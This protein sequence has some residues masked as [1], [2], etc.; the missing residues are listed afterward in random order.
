MAVRILF[1]KSLAAEWTQVNPIL[2]DGEPGVE[3]DTLRMKFGDGATA[4]VD[5]PYTSPGADGPQGEKGDFSYASDLIGTSITELTIEDDVHNLTATTGKNWAPGMWMTLAYTTDPTNYMVGLCISY[6]QFSGALQVYVNGAIYGTD[7]GPHS[8]W[9]LSYAASAG[10]SVIHANSHIPGQADELPMASAS[11][12]GF[13]DPTKFSLLEQI[14]ISG[15]FI[16]DTQPIDMPAGSVWFNTSDVVTSPPSVTAIYPQ[17]ELVDI[18]FSIDV[19]LTDAYDM[20]LVYLVVTATTNSG[21][22]PLSAI[23]TRGSGNHQFVDITACA[24]AGSAIITITAVN[25]LGLSTDVA[26]PVYIVTEAYTITASAG[27]HGTIVPSG[28]ILVPS[29]GTKLFTTTANTGYALQKFTVDSVDYTGSNSYS[30]DMEGTDHTIVATFVLGY[31]ITASITAAGGGTLAPNG[32]VTV[33][34][35]DDL[36]LNFAGSTGYEPYQYFIDNDGVPHDASSGT[37]TFNNVA[38]NHNFSVSF[39]AADFT[40]TWTSLT[41]GLIEGQASGTTTAA[42]GGAATVAIAPA[43]DYERTEVLQGG[44][45]VNTS[46]VTTSANYTFSNV[47]ADTAIGATFRIQVPQAVAAPTLTVATTQLTPT[48]SSVSRAASYNV[49]YKINGTGTPDGTWTKITGTTS[50]T[51]LT[52]LTDYSSYGVVIESVNDTG[53][54]YGSLGTAIPEPVACLKLVG[55]SASPTYNLAMIPLSGN[56]NTPLHLYFYDDGSSNVQYSVR[57]EGSGTLVYAGVYS[58]ISDTYYWYQINA[59]NYASTKVRSVGWHKIE[60]S[61]GTGSSETI[62]IDGTTIWTGT[63]GLTYANKIRL[64]GMNLLGTTSAYVVKYDKLVENGTLVPNQDTI[65]TYTLQFVDGLGAI[66]IDTT[67]YCPLPY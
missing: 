42:Y 61:N 26:I 38:T 28:E 53:T 24:T 47:T 63:S 32:Q 43:T 12:P 62:K 41:N 54:T 17:Y 29:T 66:T 4:W 58:T 35:G 2:A 21:I 67:S 51:A 11:T 36:T 8:L 48:W 20:N 30:I 13:L 22:I 16:G 46:V 50:G 25:G 19:Y 23:S 39:K 49:H 1:R 18:A 40:L 37:Y 27:A 14:E 57:F 9:T 6:N 59:V 7:P 5:L 45:A 56:V 64:K 34:A 55:S 3:R 52:S 10:S 15:A 44:V 33:A 60:F 31:T 65:G